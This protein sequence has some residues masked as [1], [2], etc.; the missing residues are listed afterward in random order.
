MKLAEVLKVPP[1][2]MVRR[3]EG[4]LAEERKPSR[5]AEFSSK[6]A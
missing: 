5:A 6:T 2:E 1:S 3:M 4:F